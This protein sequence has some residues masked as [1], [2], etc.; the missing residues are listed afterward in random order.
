VS[1]E[2]VRDELPS[3]DHRYREELIEIR[4]RGVAALEQDVEVR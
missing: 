3:A 4:D 2:P 1:P